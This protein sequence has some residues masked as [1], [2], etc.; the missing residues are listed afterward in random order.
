MKNHGAKSTEKSSS[1][2]TPT[3]FGPLSSVLHHPT[4]A[5]PALLCGQ[6]VLR[7]Q[8]SVVR[9]P[10]SGLR[11]LCSLL[12]KSST[13]LELRFALK[14]SPTMHRNERMKMFHRSEPREWRHSC[15][16][17]SVS[18]ASCAPPRP[19]VRLPSTA[20][21]LPSSAVRRPL[22]VIRPPFS[23]FPPV[24]ILPP[25]VYRPPPSA[26]GGIAK[27]SPANAPNTS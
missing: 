22:S 9:R 7:R 15:R 11:S 25:S 3:C 16:P 19:I 18:R 10:P 24:Q 1:R 27:P 4:S 8:S 21:R 14:K 23:P 13:F 20:Y 5:P 26:F 2:T 17:P 12:F 6:S